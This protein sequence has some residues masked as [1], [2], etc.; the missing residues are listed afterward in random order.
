MKELFKQISTINTYPVNE[1][2]PTENDKSKP[3]NNP[4]KSQTS[5]PEIIISEN[6]RN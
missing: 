6:E 3:K 5:K 2:L 4:L 1:S